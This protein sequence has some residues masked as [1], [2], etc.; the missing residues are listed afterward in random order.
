MKA[1]QA[2]LLGVAAACAI[3]AGMVGVAQAQD[4]GDS[5]GSG[6]SWWDGVDISFGGFIRPEASFSTSSYDNPNNQLGNTFNGRSIPRAAYVPPT[7]VG[8]A[9]PLPIV[10]PLLSGIQG[11]V[12]N[13]TSVPIR[14]LD[15]LG[16]LVADA[17]SPGLRG[18][19]SADGTGMPFETVDNDIN[20][21]ILRAELEM[22]VQLS[23]DF[24]FIARVRGIYDPG[25]Y[26]EFD[27]RKY[28]NV[29]GGIQS[30]PDALYQ[31][32]PNY[33]GY[34]VEGGGNAN[35]LEWA[36][37][38]YQVYFPALF[39]EYNA[40]PLNM[41][42]GNQQIAWGQAIFFRVFDVVNGLDLRRHS[43]LDYAQEE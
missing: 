41:R 39:L 26:D 13:W 8:A 38:N 23:Q 1:K 32:T 6:G 30:R 24:K 14:T 7:F 16:A 20:Y 43:L 11:G 12:T 3:S 9:L 17:D 40:G 36:G 10:G 29:N 33:F 15:P 42:L 28:E 37:E 22:G 27:A 2:R 25:E 18:R 5:G 21:Q 19:S 35:P 31:S 4:E 34:E